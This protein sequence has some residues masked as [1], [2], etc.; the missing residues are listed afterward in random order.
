M[1]YLYPGEVVVS[2]GPVGL[3][4]VLL[5]KRVPWEVAETNPCTEPGNE[6]HPLLQ[7]RGHRCQKLTRCPVCLSSLCQEKEYLQQS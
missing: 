3:Y 6:V 4:E 7:S 2:H 1:R 5:L